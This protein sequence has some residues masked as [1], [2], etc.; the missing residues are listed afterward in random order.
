MQKV[1][2]PL[3]ACWCAAKHV[4]LISINPPTIKHFCFIVLVTFS[5][6]DTTEQFVQNNKL[7]SQNI[8]EMKERNIYFFTEVLFL[9]HILWTTTSDF[10]QFGI[11]MSAE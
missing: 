2:N 7:C 9:F 8:L 6:R 4:C 3:T 10:W 1:P 11:S 5:R